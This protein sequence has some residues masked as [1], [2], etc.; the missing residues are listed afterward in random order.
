MT[1]ARSRKARRTVKTEL[2]ERLA[3][4]VG[5]KGLILDRADMLAYLEEPRGLY[6]GAARCVVRPSTVDETAAVIRLCNDYRVAVVP[7][8]GNTGL[9][10]GQTPDESG[11]QVLLSLQRMNAIREIDVGSDTMTVEAGVTLARAQDAAA[12]VDRYFPLSYASEGSATIGGALSTN[13]GGIHVLAYGSAGDFALGIEV[14]LADGRILSGLSKL[15]K[16]NTG[17]HLTRLF[18]GAE[19]TLGVVT[20]ATLKLFP[21][22][23][24]HA[25]AFVAL[26]DPEKALE[27][28]HLA[29]RELGP[30]LHAFELIPRIGVDLVLRSG[31]GARAPFSDHHPWHVLLETSVFDGTPPEETMF[32]MLSKALESGLARDAAVAASLDQRAA[33]WRIR[34]LLPEAQKHEG[35]SIKHD[36]SLPLQ[37]IPQFLAEAAAGVECCIPG[38]RPVPFGHLGDGNIHYNVT[39]PP[40]ADRDA[41][42]S[43]RAELN[44]AVHAIVLL[45]GGS[46]SAEHGVGRLKRELLEQ[47][48][49]PVSLG[50]MRSIKSVLDPNFIMNPGKVLTAR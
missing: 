14:A 17:Y 25:T 41:F 6:H 3:A 4:I 15:R 29:K 13:A 5:D 11:E 34:E 42:L 21:S 45:H 40:G 38:A 24:A 30:S 32:A 22:P 26:D 43:R 1:A 47:V 8:G 7:Q 36:V 33:F 18:I 12:S 48:K 49:D 19:G 50:V 27:F 44:E 2:I 23:R 28:L 46:I 31:V 39:Q 37:K 16:D 9:V 10:G 35:G 20:A